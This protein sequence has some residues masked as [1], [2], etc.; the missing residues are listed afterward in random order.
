MPL[1]S[2]LFSDLMYGCKQHRALTWR[3][4][5]DDS[6]KFTFDTPAEVS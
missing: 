2:N 6:R 4:P 1:D 5:N 3:M